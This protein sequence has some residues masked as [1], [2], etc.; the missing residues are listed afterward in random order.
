MSCSIHKDTRLTKEYIY[1]NSLSEKSEL[2]GANNTTCP[3]VLAN[4]FCLSYKKTQTIGR[5]TV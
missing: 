5:S 4:I 2:T 3:K 1:F